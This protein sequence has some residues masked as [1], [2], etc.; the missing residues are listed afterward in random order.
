MTRTHFLSA[1]LGLALSA[2]LLRAA[3]P[4]PPVSTGPT[5]NTLS[6][7]FS[8]HGTVPTDA[9][10]QHYSLLYEGQYNEALTMFKTVDLA[11]GIKTSNGPWIDS[12]C[13]YTAVGECYY[14][15]GR[16]GDALDNY[17][18]A[19]RLYMQ[20]SDWMLQIKFQA[21]SS[22]PPLQTPWGAS[23][24]GLKVARMP[25]N[26]LIA[27]GSLYIDQQLQQ[28][29]VVAPAQLSPVNVVEI[30][31]CTLLALKRRAE[32]MGPVC[33]H[34]QLTADLLATFQRHPGPRNHWSEA[35]VDAQLGM[36][37]VG[38]GET[39]QALAVLKR[40]LVLGGE[41]DHPLTPV[42]LLELG[43]LAA[44]AGDFTSAS[45]YLEEA[46][47]SAVTFNDYTSL[48]EAFRYGQV[49]H[50]MASRPGI[51]PPLAKAIQWAS[52]AR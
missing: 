23:T 1:L 25:G 43:Q 51:F 7:P 44:E 2:T 36:A 20:F 39:G 48:E 9:Y 30:N 34:D 17:N 45:R 5:L 10:L 21:F 49:V 29:G 12:I 33:P 18:A 46:S 40:S 24:R 26:M 31:R 8:T 32:L 13:Y 27:Q 41:F 6:T 47:Y 16:L 35:W 42:T 14:R 50:L 19:L 28:G 37:L 4:T 15:L 11:S 3:G 52:L 38:A 22:N